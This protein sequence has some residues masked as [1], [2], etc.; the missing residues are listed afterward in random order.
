MLPQAFLI[1]DELLRTT[2][3]V[4]KGLN[5][6]NEA[7]QRNLE[8]YAPFAATERVMMA[9]ARKG[10]DRQDMHER[11]RGHALAAWEAVQVGKDNPLADLLKTD[12]GI[13]KFLEESDIDGLM[14]VSAYTGI[15]AARAREM[16]A[17]IHTV[18][19]ELKEE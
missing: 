18:L 7:I 1:S 10:A 17:R 19:D 8:A 14:D 15:A 5:I 9:A 13:S 2:L 16:V 3:K 4:M 12:T 11:L 6:H